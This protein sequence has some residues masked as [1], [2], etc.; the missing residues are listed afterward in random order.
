MTHHTQETL[1][2]QQ[3]DPQAQSYLTSAVH[4]SGEDL[5]AL[6]ALIGQRPDAIALDLG[7]GAGHATFLLA[8]R[9]REV[10]AYDLSAT[11]IAVTHAEALR[12]GCHNVVTRQG[13]AARLPF[14]DASFDLVV[15]RYS[16]HHWQD[17][18]GGLREARR[19]LKPGGLAVFMDV[20]APAAQLPDTW[21]QS[22]ELL[23]DPSHVRNYTLAQWHG[24]LGAAG[25]GPATTHV[26]RVGLQF[27]AWTLRMNTP[28]AQVSAIRALQRAAPQEVLRHFDLQDDGT[29]T[30]DSLLMQMHA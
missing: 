23:R 14:D 29:F 25:F 7:C 8:A 17:A 3:F 22:L 28:A 21:L 10:T 26:F 13:V 15:S 24:M 9:V 4:A 12:R 11:M 27:Q 16:V 6:A 19:V 1:V 30:V 18:A 5:Q 2:R 20:F